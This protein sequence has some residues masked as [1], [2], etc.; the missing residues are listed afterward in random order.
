MTYKALLSAALCRFSGVPIYSFLF[1]SL[2]SNH[3]DLC[4][5]ANTLGM[6]HDRTCVFAVPCSWIALPPDAHMISSL[7]SGQFKVILF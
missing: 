7:P 1:Y 5:F 4:C 6:L 3:I 2:D